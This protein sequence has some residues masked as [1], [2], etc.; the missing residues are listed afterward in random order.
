MGVGRLRRYYC[1]LG[2]TLANIGA[3]KWG[4]RAPKDTYKN[5]G[6]NMGVI[7]VDAT[8]RGG[9]VYGANQ[10]RPARVNITYVSA[11]LGGGEGNDI[12]RSVR[13]FCDPDSLNDVLFGS[14]NGKKIFVVDLD[15]GGGTEYDIENVTLP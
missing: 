3:I 15:D 10:P 11:N 14:I 6:A 1:N 4:F 13:R 5:I 2:G 12:V 7:Q 9:I 8:N